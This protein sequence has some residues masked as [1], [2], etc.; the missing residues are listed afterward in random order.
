[1]QKSL[2]RFL[3]D[4]SGNIAIFSAVVMILVMGMAAFGVDVGKMFADRRTAQSTTDIAALVAASNIT[5]AP[6]A[7]AA[8]MTSNNLNAT[9]P[10]NIQYGIYTANPAIP[11]AQRFVTS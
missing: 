1:M 6:A 5:N 10:A 4:R 9:A 8:A 3:A 7:V 11:V 2:K